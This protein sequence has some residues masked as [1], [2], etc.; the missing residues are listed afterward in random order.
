[1]VPL[2]VVTVTCILT[3]GTT[4]ASWDIQYTGKSAVT[5]TGS[6]V[7]ATSPTLVT[8]NL[9][10]PSALVLTN[11]TGTPSAIGLANGTGLPL[12][13]GVTGTLPIANGGTGQTS[14]TNAFNALSPLTTQGDILYYNGT[15]NVRLAA[16][17]SGQ[18]LKTL[19]AGANPA[20]ADAASAGWTFL[21]SSAT[22]SGSSVTITGIPST[23]VAVWVVGTGISMTADNQSIGLQLGDSG[24]LET[25][26]YAG[27]CSWVKSTTPAAGQ[28]AAAAMAQAVGGVT[29]NA[30]DYT[31]TFL[32][33][34]NSQVSNQWVIN[35][36]I[37]GS[38]NGPGNPLGG[39]GTGRKATSAT[40]DRVAL[41][42]GGTF[43]AGTMYV[44]YK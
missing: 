35:T 42:T 39:S 28:W 29:D 41:V 10:T 18:F 40:M 33:Q 6:M 19:G 44:F 5:G 22:T 34:L 4:A 38:A 8:P 9:G 25:N 16:G 32:L 23:A 26:A 27:S 43:D 11:A 21:N 37:G 12:T 20:W 15:N 13:T 24:G 30:D 17:T 2:S 36:G 1:M 31:V 14:A 3:S 7:L